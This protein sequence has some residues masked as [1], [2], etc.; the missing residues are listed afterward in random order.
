MRIY[1][2]PSIIS[3]YLNL[4]PEKKQMAIKIYPVSADDRED[5][6]QLWLGYQEFYGADLRSGTEA[7]WKR[8]LSPPRD[9][10][11]CLVAETEDGKLCGLA[12]YLYHTTTWSAGPRCYLN[13]LFTDVNARGRGVGRALIEA[14]YVAADERDAGQVYWHTQ[15]FNEKARILYDKVAKV[16]P[17]IKYVR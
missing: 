9:G 4:K 16:T 12:H 5:W 17:F 8:L 14:V 2:V 15:E 11:F 6:E 3:V 1:V 13:D 7:I 10:P